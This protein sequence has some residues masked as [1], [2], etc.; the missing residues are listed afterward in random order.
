MKKILT[1]CLITSALS[2]SSNS[3]CM[4]MRTQRITRA[5]KVFTPQKRLNFRAGVLT[6][7][8]YKE[9]L[10][11]EKYYEEYFLED[12]EF[13]KKVE[14]QQLT[15]IENLLEKN[16]EFLRNVLKQNVLLAEMSYMPYSSSDPKVLYHKIDKLAIDAWAHEK[17]K[18]E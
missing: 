16:N 6:Q 7:E 9:S 5:K 4:F 8:E 3:F 14:N 1:L 15:R 2:I 18:K 11:E 17:T 12:P 10:A 13:R